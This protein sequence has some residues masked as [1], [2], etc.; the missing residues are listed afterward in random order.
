MLTV[1]SGG[2]L[3]TLKTLFNDVTGKQKT[4]WFKFETNL[5]FNLFKFLEI[6]CYS[7]DD[8]RFNYKN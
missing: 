3:T 8:T 5:M 4:K 7:Y 6:W 1:S 2:K